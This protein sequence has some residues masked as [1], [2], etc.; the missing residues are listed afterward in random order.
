AM[1]PILLVLVLVLV[2]DLSSWFR[3][4]GRGR[5]RRGS[6][7]VTSVRFS[8][9]TGTLNPG[10]AASRQSAAIRG[11]NQPVALCRDAATG[12]TVHGGPPCS[13]VTTSTLC[14]IRGGRIGR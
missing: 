5:G 2:L 12:R 13:T 1:N 9:S 6:S 7:W 14:G 4:R 8:A 10:V 11:N 3:G